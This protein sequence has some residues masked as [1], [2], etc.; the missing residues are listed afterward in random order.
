MKHLTATVLLSAL[1]FGTT[2]M[3]GT[4]HE[5]DAKGGHAHGPVSSDVATERATKKMEQLAKSGKIE[6]TWSGTKA[7]SVEQKTYAKGP[8]WVV[9]F[10]NEKAADA[11]KQT[12][13][14]FYSL[15]GHYIAAN[16]TG[17]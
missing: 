14:L 8:E 2:A 15:E 17:S 16:F 7:R 4:G 3:A 11:T 5:H 6:S 9:I 10:K 1:L 13:Y 12:L